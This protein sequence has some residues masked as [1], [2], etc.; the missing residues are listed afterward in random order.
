MDI[1]LGVKNRLFTTLKNNSVYIQLKRQIN[2]YNLSMLTY[3]SLL[4][5][6][7]QNKNKKSLKKILSIFNS[8]KRII[9]KIILKIKK[10][11]P[12]NEFC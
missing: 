1:F 8:N 4:K 7:N 11:L 2:Y 3:F 12:Y 6:N 9:I 5:Y 10:K